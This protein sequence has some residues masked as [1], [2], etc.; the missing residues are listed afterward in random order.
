LLQADLRDSEISDAQLT[1]AAGL[2][3]FSWYITPQL[4]NVPNYHKIY[5]MD[6]KLTK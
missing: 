1:D 2:P 3:D 4:E 5:Q 6:T